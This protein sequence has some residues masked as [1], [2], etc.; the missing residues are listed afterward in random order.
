MSGPNL[1]SK[2]MKPKKLY[3]EVY[4]F[5]SY[6]ALFL[7]HLKPPNGEEGTLAQFRHAVGTALTAIAARYNAK[8]SERDSELGQMTERGKE[9]HRHIKATLKRYL[10]SIPARMRKNV[11]RP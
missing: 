7:H 11:W 8:I 6:G 4:N 2:H 1:N 10:Q 5:E 3:G 9:S